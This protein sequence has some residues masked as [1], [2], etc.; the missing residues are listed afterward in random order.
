MDAQPP[1]SLAL[2]VEAWRML[3]L[4]GDWIPIWIQWHRT[5]NHITVLNDGWQFSLPHMPGVASD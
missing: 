5:L 3:T 1:K 4:E 2:T